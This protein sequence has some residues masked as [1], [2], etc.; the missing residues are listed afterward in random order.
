MVT[1]REMKMGIR[2][3]WVLGERPN[4]PPGNR[5]G[6]KRRSREYKY[7]GHNRLGPFPGSSKNKGK[8]KRMENTR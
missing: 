1:L 5:R 7:R 4:R 6:R 3:T 8:K 2:H